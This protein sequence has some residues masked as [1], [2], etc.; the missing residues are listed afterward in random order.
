[1][2]I[3]ECAKKITVHEKGKNQVSIAQVMEILKVLN[4]IM[5]GSLYPMIKAIR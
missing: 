1:M 4:K 3:T 5:K 2:K